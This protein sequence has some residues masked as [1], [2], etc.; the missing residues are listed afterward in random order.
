MKSFWIF[1]NDLWC[2]YERKEREIWAHGEGGPMKTDAE[3]GVLFPQA[4][5]HQEPAASGGGKKESPPE[6]LEGVCPADSLIP[7]FH[8]LEPWENK[9]LLFEDIQ[10]WVLFLRAALG[11]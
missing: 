11:N 5:E 8:L 1:E 4:K 9:F 6:L 2:L 10:F 3:I 7:H